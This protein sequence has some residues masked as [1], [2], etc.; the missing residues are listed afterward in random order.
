MGRRL[1]AAPDRSEIRRSF[2][3]ARGPEDGR[4]LIRATRRPP[5]VLVRAARVR[6]KA[7]GSAFHHRARPAFLKR[8]TPADSHF[9]AALPPGDFAAGESL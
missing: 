8:K 5:A 6:R 4:A 3:D 9:G 2:R 7:D 1:V